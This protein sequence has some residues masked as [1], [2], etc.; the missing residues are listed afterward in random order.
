MFDVELH[1]GKQSLFIIHLILL[2]TLQRLYVQCI[3]TNLISEYFTHV[4]TE[5]A[6]G[7]CWVICCVENMLS[8]QHEQVAM[9]KIGSVEKW[10]CV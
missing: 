10:K 4:R 9:S 5:I 6:L 1:A 7:A 3:I 2:S 8:F